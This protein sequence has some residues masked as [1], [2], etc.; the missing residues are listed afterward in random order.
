M[1]LTQS[2]FV[3]AAALVSIQAGALNARVSKISANRSKLMIVSDHLGDMKVGDI[4]TTGADCKLEVVQRNRKQAILSTSLCNSSG[5]FERGQV[6][7]I[8]EAAPQAPSTISA[9][10]ASASTYQEQTNYNGWVKRKD[11]GVSNGVR[12]SVG[13]SALAAGG[14]VSGAG[15][16][17]TS[18]SSAKTNFSLGVGYANIRNQEFGYVARGVY[19]AFVSDGG[20]VSTVRAEGNAAY[21]LND[22][23]YLFAGLNLA[24]LMSQG[25][26][27][28]IGLGGQAGIGYQFSKVIGIDFSILDMNSST[29]L[30]GYAVDISLVGIELA[31]HATF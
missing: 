20:G 15:S 21:G 16:S 31:L 9:A 10:T 14:K 1:K 30:G 19:T 4:V 2:M 24:K 12:F 18:Y 25:F 28:S 3:V 7:S 23:T 29:K 5:S 27:F 17:A 11:Y 13:T 8:N 6:V 22:S 26:D